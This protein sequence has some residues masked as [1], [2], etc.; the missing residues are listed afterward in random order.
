M[1]SCYTI[2]VVNYPAWNYLQRKRK[3]LCRAA[4][5][6]PELIRKAAEKGRK[7]K[8][9]NGC[10]AKLVEVSS[11]TYRL[12]RSPQIQIVRPDTKIGVAIAPARGSSS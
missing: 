4:I 1:Q 11:G 3:P 12:E 9:A 5:A 2:L 7:E 10:P 8:S 6:R